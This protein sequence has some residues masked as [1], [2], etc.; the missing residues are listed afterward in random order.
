L[1]PADIVPLG[2]P[3]RTEPDFVFFP[4]N[5]VPVPYYGVIELKKPSSQIVSTT[6][7]NVVI[8]SRDAE[9]AIQQSVVYTKNIAHYAPIALEESPVFLGNRAHIF[10]IMGMT[11][12]IGEK[13]AVEV[14]REM[15]A[16]RLPT[17]LQLMPYDGLLKMFES[18]LPPRFYFLRPTSESREQLIVAINESWVL[19]YEIAESFGHKH[20]AEFARSSHGFHTDWLVRTWLPT[21]YGDVDSLREQISRIDGRFD[22]RGT[23]SS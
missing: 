17:N 4:K 10:V 19:I 16:N 5:T 12:E 9:T 20:R 18:Q 15:V 21:K 22:C 13:L 3:G 7:A 1:E 23:A 2:R 14:Y 11:A 8:L 6:R